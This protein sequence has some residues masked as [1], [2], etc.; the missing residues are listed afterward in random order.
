MLVTSIR[1]KSGELPSTDTLL[2][3]TAT[4]ERAFARAGFITNVEP[5]A[6]D[7]RSN[8]KIGLHMRSFRID[9][10][11]LGPNADHSCSGRMCK[12]GYKLTDIPTW[13]QRESFNHIVNDAFDKLKLSARIKSGE[14]LIRDKVHG[15]VNEWNSSNARS[16]EIKALKAVQS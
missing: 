1:T 10:A 16:F 2:K 8:M 12:A 6:N 4:L 3:L 15:R 13:A 5:G 9:K 14:F 7:S 11:V